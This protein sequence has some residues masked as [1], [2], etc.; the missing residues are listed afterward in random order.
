MLNQIALVTVGLLRLKRGLQDMPGSRE[1]LIV[2]I[3]A[4]VS[5][6]LG[7]FRMQE[8]PWADA[9]SAALLG[10]ALL[11]LFIWGV[12]AAARKAARVRQTFT[13]LLAANTALELIG[14]I[15]T[16]QVKPWQKQFQQSVE[17][18]GIEAATA[19]MQ[20]PPVGAFSIII[21]VF[22]WF[23]VV[24]MHVLKHA[25]ETSYLQAALVATLYPMV[26][27]MLS[28]PFLRGG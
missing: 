10:M 4:Y 17:E 15:P 24:M 23:L 18:V 19:M 2:V 28:L 14:L 5:V 26:I 21:V 9:I 3:L 20:D 22:L 13:S 16:W 11:W 6:A 25:L 27:V 1:A 12:L 7:S 8:L